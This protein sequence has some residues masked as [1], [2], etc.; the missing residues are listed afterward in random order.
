V[1]PTLR[2]VLPRLARRRL[3]LAALTVGALVV[4]EWIGEDP[5][6]APLAVAVLAYASPVIALGVALWC[7]FPPRREVQKWRTLVATAAGA[8][9]I[10]GYLTGGSVAKRA[11]DDC[12]ARIGFV[13]TALEAHRRA[14]GR[15]PDRLTELSYVEPPGRR[16]LRGSLLRY[17]TDGA[18]YRLTFGDWKTKAVYTERTAPDSERALR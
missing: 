14:V 1:T 2:I 4:G 17:T 5:Y 18:T 12:Y 13:R 16:L 7:W 3:S 8:G 10:A 11:L 6:V 9:L 15:Y